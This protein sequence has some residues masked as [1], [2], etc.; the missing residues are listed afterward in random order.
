MTI[1][2]DTSTVQVHGQDWPAGTSGSRAGLTA[3]RGA[4]RRVTGVFG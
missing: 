2:V 3:L 4:I 1:G